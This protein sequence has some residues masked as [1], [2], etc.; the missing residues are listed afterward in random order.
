LLLKP[1]LLKIP[2]KMKTFAD[3]VIDFNK[4]LDLDIVLPDGIRIMNPF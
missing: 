3:R 4:S 1:Y 2:G